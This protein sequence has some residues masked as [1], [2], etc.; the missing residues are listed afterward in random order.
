MPRRNVALLNLAAIL[1]CGSH[2]CTQTR[3]TTTVS[4]A[5]E[6]PAPERLPP[7]TPRVTSPVETPLFDM[8]RRFASVEVAPWHEPVPLL[9]P[10][11]RHSADIA[12]LL[13]AIET[14][15]TETEY[16]HRTSVN[17]RRGR[18]RWDC[19]GMAGWILE[20]EAG[21]AFEAMDDER[22]VARDFYDMIEDAPSDR[23]RHGWQ[24]IVG[25]AQ[26]APG[27]MFAWRKPV[28][29][30][31]RPNTGHVGFILETP[32]PH[33]VHENVWLFRIADSTSIPHENDSRE[34]GDGGG[35][36]TATIA[37]MVDAEGNPIAYGWHG[38]RQDPER[39]VHTRI[40]FGRVSR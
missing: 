27:D 23:S 19:S 33:P 36:G 4:P 22:P 6:V 15:L 37:F 16:R 39:F 1:V 38:S 2:G 20:R 12:E 25:P 26:L 5:I 18:Y 40:G 10:A 35:F 31:H 14:R 13:A 8:P 29:W 9:E 3:S 17:H 11:N 7:E 32:Q 34:R 21:R 24:R 28:A 30:R